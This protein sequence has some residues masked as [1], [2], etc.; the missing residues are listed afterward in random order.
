MRPLFNTGA[1]KVLFN[2]SVT[3]MRIVGVA[4]AKLLTIRFLLDAFGTEG[5]GVFLAATS[6]ALLTA[7]LTGAMQT[8][9]LRAISLEAPR[10][11]DMRGVFSNLFGMHVITAA[12]MLALGGVCGYLL[13]NY[14]MVIPPELLEDANFA[15]FCIFSAT[16]VGNI[17]SLYEVFLQSK[18]RLEIFAVLDVLQAWML[19]PVS[20]WLIYQDGD[21]IKIYAGIVAFLSVL[22]L[23]VVAF[24]TMRDYPETRVKLS[25][26]FNSEFMRHHGWIASWSLVGA[27]SAVARHQGLVLL[28]NITG[29]PIANAIFGIANQIPSLL[30]QFASTFQLVLAPRIYGKEAVGDRDQMTAHVFAVCRLASILTLIVAIPIAVEM[31]NLLQ[32]WLGDYEKIA[33]T[34]G[35]ILLI[36]LVIEQSAAGTGLAHLALGRVARFN[37]VAGGLSIMMLPTAY[38]I[39]QFTGEFLHILYTLICF[40]GLVAATTMRLLYPEIKD[41]IKKW[42]SQTLIPI[43]FFA[44]PPLLMA[45]IVTGIFD[46]SLGRLLLTIITSLITSIPSAFFLGLNQSERQQLKSVFLSWKKAQ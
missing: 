14:V 46:P 36:A 2:T 42:V 13:I 28:V 30:R 17:F 16:V 9:S 35:L 24:I 3:W 40:T 15:F 41:P 4:L 44:A 6:V 37:I 39:T 27:I 32:L 43:S 26:L 5:F 34:V 29:G 18:E 33:V 31:P 11:V 20:F 23:W 25:S 38:M 12:V 8:T 22:G 21:L 10:G 19:V 7:M 45:F 1:G